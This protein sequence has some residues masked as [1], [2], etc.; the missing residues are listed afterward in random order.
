M[1]EQMWHG[2]FK[3][4]ID[5]YNAT[6]TLKKHLVIDD[7]FYQEIRSDLLDEIIETFRSEV[8]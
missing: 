8:E 2:I 3:K 5:C 1:N 6:Q 4:Y 7:D